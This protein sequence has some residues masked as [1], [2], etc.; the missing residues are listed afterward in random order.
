VTTGPVASSRSDGQSFL[1]EGLAHFLV[2]TLS[3]RALVA[4][5]I[6]AVKLEKA[7]RRWFINLDAVMRGDQ[8]QD[9]VNVRQMIIGHVGQKGA[10]DSSVAQAPVQ[11][12]QKEAKLRQQ[13]ESNN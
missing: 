7:E 5:R 9:V 6:P 2:H 10:L 1:R 8:P 3:G 4:G 11:P 12:A 13:C